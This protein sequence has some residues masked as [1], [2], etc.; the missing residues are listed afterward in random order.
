MNLTQL[1]SE[2]TQYGLYENWESL[3]CANRRT[4][5]C[6]HVRVRD[7][8]ETP[9]GRKML[10]P[11]G[12]GSWLNT[13]GVGGLVGLNFGEAPS[14]VAASPIITLNWL[15]GFGCVGYGVRE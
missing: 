11:L 12:E 1:P 7:E 2:V 9:N 13:H 15:T 4:E 6:V 10:G 3:V 14:G 8:L 5:H